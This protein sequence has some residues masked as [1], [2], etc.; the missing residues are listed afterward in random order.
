MK[1]K[2]KKLHDK[3]IIPK[4]QTEGASGFDLHYCPQDGK[5]IILQSGQVSLI[6]T[7]I[8]AEI[9]V[10]YELQVRSRS[11][12][13]YKNHVY[14]LN[15]PG[16]VD[17]DY[18]GEIGVILHNFSVYNFHIQPGDRIAQLVPVQLPTVLVEVVDEL[19]DTER[20]AGGF[21]STGHKSHKF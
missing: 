16:T 10:G 3:A 9:P 20:G 21:G 13:A 7:G 15:A 11:G 1:L 14:V 5:E 18:R 12:L 19:S 17:A 6:P 2:F 4:R 8:S